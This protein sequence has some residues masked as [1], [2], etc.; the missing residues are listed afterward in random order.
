MKGVSVGRFSHLIKVVKYAGL[1][2]WRSE[3]CHT[4]HWS[5]M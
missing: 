4:W 1:L 5:A 3:T 2:F